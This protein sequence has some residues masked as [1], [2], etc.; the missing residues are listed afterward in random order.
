MVFGTISCGEFAVDGFFLLSGYLIM[1]SWDSK[2]QAWEFLKKRLLRIYPGFIVASLIC[3]FLVG[4]LGSEP[5]AYFS[6]FDEANFVRALLFLDIP[7]IPPVFEGTPYANINGSMWTIS[8]EFMCYLFILVAGV[9]GALRWRHFCLGVT[10][11]VFAVLAWLK[12]QNVPVLDLRLASFFLSG[13][14]Y[15]RYRDV[16]RLDGRAAI[17]AIT[18]VILGLCSW[19]GAELVLASV[20]GY[21]LLYVASKRSALL[22]QF[23]RLPDVSYGVYL[24]GWPIQKLLL[25][26]DPSMSPWTLFVLAAAGSLVAGTI[27]WHII[28]KPALRFK[29]PSIRI[30]EQPEV[31]TQ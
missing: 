3:A 4:P 27:S 16:V 29:S 5:T 8:R 10:I 6:A 7:A 25:W 30:Q 1:Q 31:A 28:E 21:A 9:S 11:A 14:C 26:H 20:G 12:L 15:Y 18:M 24:Y 22:S 23:N 13:A 19:R 2:P 17:T